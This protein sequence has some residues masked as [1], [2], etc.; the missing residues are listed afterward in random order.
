M[1]VRRVRI[2]VAATALVAATLTGCATT[3][4]GSGEQLAP[5][6]QQTGFPAPPASGSPGAT[7][8]PSATSPGPGTAPT[9][10]PSGT[11]STQPDDF[12]CPK[13]VYPLAHLTFGCIVDGLTV[14]K[15]GFWPVSLQKSVEQATGWAVEEGA[16]SW[17]NPGSAPLDDVAAQV[18]SSMIDSGSYGESPRVKTE[19]AMGVQVGGVPARVIQSRITLNPT[20]AKA[21]ATKVTSE[22]LWIVVMKVSRTSNSLWFVSIPNLV[23]ALWT[24]VPALIKTIQV[25]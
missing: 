15:A 18:R 8:T 20:W 23:S 9:P 7:A 13:I 14:R 21:R 12:S 24:K 1:R 3:L 10:T 25:G 6:Q 16:G 2:A 11:A 5:T 4:A 19:H 17:D 22:K